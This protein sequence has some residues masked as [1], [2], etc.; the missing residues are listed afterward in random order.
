MIHPSIGELT[1]DKN[2]NRYS[3]VVATAKCAR[4]IT[5]EYVKQKDYADKLAIS[6][7]GEKKSTLTNLIDRSYRDEKAV[8][9]A[10]AGLYAGDFKVVEV[11][12]EE[13]LLGKGDTEAGA[14]VEE[15]NEYTDN[16]ALNP[17]ENKKHTE[18]AK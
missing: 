14:D 9:T 2:I 11:D 8:K 12:G 7:E 15:T 1:G 16:Y 18:I 17:N 4:I 13:V 10:I 5:D 3:L 6:K